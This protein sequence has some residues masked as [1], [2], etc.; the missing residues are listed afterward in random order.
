MDMVLRSLAESIVRLRSVL[1]VVAGFFVLAVVS[2]EA[3]NVLDE[4]S[5]QHSDTYVFI[6]FLCLNSSLNSASVFF[7]LI[8]RESSV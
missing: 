3:V 8:P 4:M 7:L 6:I 5:D 1:V 2:S